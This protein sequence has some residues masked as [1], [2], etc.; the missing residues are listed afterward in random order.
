MDSFQA[1]YD[2]LGV[3][4]ISLT[5]RVFTAT[6]STK[7][8]NAF[9]ARRLQG[10]RRA[11][12]VFIPNTRGSPNSL[13]SFERR[14]ERVTMP[15]RTWRH[16]PFGRRNG[17]GANHLFNGLTRDHFE[18]LFITT[19]K[20]FSAE[21]REIPELSH[22]WFGT[23]LGED[24]KAIKTRDGQPVKLADLLNEAI[25][26]AGRMV[27]EKKPDLAEDEI[28]KRAKVIGLGAVKY[29]D[30]S[31]DRTLDMSFRGTNRWSCRVTPPPICNTR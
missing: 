14:M 15:R 25:E 2:M 3:Q 20:W 8:T 7:C 31:Q 26:R 17:K 27:R 5:A 12:V 10:G 23:I 21:N 18:Q 22:A 29:A 19:R 24:N 13:S 9:R 11:L 6:G 4:S 28:T 30:L 16:C 1:I